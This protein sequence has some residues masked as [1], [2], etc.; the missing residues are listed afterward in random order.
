[1]CPFFIDEN[2][3]ISYM[4]WIQKEIVLPL[5]QRGYHII[6]H[7]IESELNHELKKIKV[8]TAYDTPEGRIKDFPVDGDIFANATPVYDELPGW[9]ED[10]SQMSSYDELPDNAKRYAKYLANTM[11]V[12][13]SLISVGSKRSQTIHLLEP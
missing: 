9:E 13:I 8:C 11:G 5:H 12:P 3:L 2:V 6:T 4:I 10:I 7:L 1:M